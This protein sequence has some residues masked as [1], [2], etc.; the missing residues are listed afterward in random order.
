MVLKW[1]EQSP[2]DTR[3]KTYFDGGL[4]GNGLSAMQCDVM[5]FQMDADLQTTEHASPACRMLP[6]A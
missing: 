6:S 4:F 1:F 5:L 3:I 2:P